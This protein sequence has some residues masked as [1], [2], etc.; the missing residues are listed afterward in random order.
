MWLN[1]KQ[2]VSMLGEGQEASLQTKIGYGLQAETQRLQVKSL[3]CYFKLSSLAIPAAWSYAEEC[4]ML[5]TSVLFKTQTCIQK[6]RY[7]ATH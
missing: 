2:L 7:I 6:G 4:V 1:G 3:C 5:L